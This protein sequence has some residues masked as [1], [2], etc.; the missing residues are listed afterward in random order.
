MQTSFTRVQTYLVPVRVRKRIRR[1]VR[2][3]DVDEV[4]Q[5]LKW[6]LYQ[7]QKESPKLLEEAGNPDDTTSVVDAML[8]AATIAISEHL[9]K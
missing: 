5:Q 3:N 7:I 8:E 4:D 6:A 2:Y 1:F 9:K